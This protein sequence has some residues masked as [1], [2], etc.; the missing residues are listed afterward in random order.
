MFFAVQNLSDL[1]IAFRSLAKS[2]GFTIIAVVTLALGIGLSASSFSIANAFLLRNVPYPESERLVRIF[3]TSP[4]SASLPHAP[5]NLLDIR[6]SLTS[7]TGIAIF[8]YDSFALG[9]A[10]QPAEQVSGLS[11][12]A[13][14]FEVLKVQPML[15][16]GFVRGDDSME[17]PRVVVLS[18]K[19]WA[20]HYGANPAAI[21]QQVRLNTLPYTI[22]GV[23]PAGF[24]APLV[25]G[26]ADYITVRMI[27]P[28]FRTQRKD[29]WMHCVARL[30]PGV[31]MARAQ[32]EA[33]TIAARLRQQY[34]AENGQD[35]LRLVDLYVSNMDHVSQALLWLM[36]ALSL[37]MLLIACANLASLQ[38][39]RALGRA[40]EFAIRSALG[41]GRAQLMMPLLVESI[42]LAIAGGVLGLL[43]ANWSN[44][45]IGSLLLIN[46]VQGFSVPIDG[47]VLAFSAIVSVLSGVAFGFAPAWL[48]ARAPA[49]EALK[50]GA[51]SATAGV[52]HHRI[53]RTLI[54]TELALAMSLVGVAA[55]FGI[56]ARTF[57]NREVG[58][59]IDGLAAGYIVL[60]YNRYTDDDKCREF[61]RAALERLRALPGLEHVTLAS[62]L[63]VFTLGRQSRLLI[64][65][66]P[67][68]EKGREPIAETAS[69]SADYF[70]TL[71][72]PLQ[73]GALFADA[74]KPSNPPVVVVNEAFARRFWPG[75][76][77]IG[78][79]FRLVENDEWLHIVGVVGDT[80]M[81]VR[82]DTPETN[83]QV[84]RPLFDRP[85]H[86]LAIVARG[87]VPPGTLV[88]P[89]RQV[90]ASLD[91]DMPVARPGVLRAE[92]DRN[93]SNIDLVIVNL[94]VSAGMGLLIA[95]VGLFGVISQLTI[96]RTRDIGVR[97][98]L[99]AQSADILS[100]VVGEG[101][102]FLVVGLLVGLPLYYG[103]NLVV[104]RVIPEAN[105]P[106]LW[107]LATDILVLGATMLV[108]CWLP[109]RR[110]ASINP[111]EALRSE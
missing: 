38:V 37:T 86:Y 31:S 29:V 22:V 93:L 90:I 105:Y 102:R 14:F 91:A 68:V 39:A 12:T 81:A 78:R 51:R 18:Y 19:T 58:W 92:L 87:R 35:G 9:E 61:S 76:T 6:E 24:D 36:T 3:R 45:I 48:A 15:G 110:A 67:A 65:R 1:R 42:A 57:L 33:D 23:L 73:E 108:A 104:R 80:R 27:E 77:A 10:G 17:R 50:D 40:R 71:R 98:A 2:P 103:L 32:A 54:I 28:Q 64:E 7:F 43:V 59:T 79:R 21:G 62:G 25:W 13:D 66:Q 20:R 100:L 88:T 41:G 96:Q 107:L 47:R 60:P 49:A 74:E 4:Q 99:G 16:R 63:P 72:I 8:N 56:G 55:S 82:P 11:V 83:L 30:R 75:A 52:S 89:I 109:A 84:Y 95:T 70:A 94:G 69:V 26:S 34:P 101:V 85:P 111:V 46:N 44:D 106:G 5:A 53:K 97:I